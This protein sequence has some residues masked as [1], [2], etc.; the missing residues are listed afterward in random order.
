MGCIVVL[1]RTLLEVI[2]GQSPPYIL[3]S[4]VESVLF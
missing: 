1:R 4:N 3:P 2:G